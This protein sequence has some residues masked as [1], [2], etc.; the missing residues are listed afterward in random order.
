M[1]K[2]KDKMVIMGVMARLNAIES[3][4][5]KLNR[6]AGDGIYDDYVTEV[7]DCKEVIEVLCEKYGMDCDKITFLNMEEGPLEMIA[8]AIDIANDSESDFKETIILNLSYLSLS[9][10][11]VFVK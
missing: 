2:M 8:E 3:Y 1:V 9:T 7:T 11:L 6:L 10:N 5:R 4:A